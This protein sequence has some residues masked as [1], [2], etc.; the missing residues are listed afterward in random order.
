MNVMKRFVKSV[1]AMN[2]P[3]HQHKLVIDTIC[4]GCVISKYKKYDKL[5]A[6]VK[7][8]SNHFNLGEY[9]EDF[10]AYYVGK[11]YEAKRILEEIGE[12]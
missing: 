1:I 5:L 6:F 8:I 12:E 7:G 9:Q 10:M 3:D 2:N 11:E 4:R